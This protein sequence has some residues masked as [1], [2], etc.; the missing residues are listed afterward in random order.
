MPKVFFTADPHIHH[1]NIIH[2]CNR[3]FSSIEEMD[4]TI[5][6]NWNSKINNEDTVYI[7]GDFVLAWSFNRA[8]E[9]IKKLNGKKILILGNHDNPQIYKKLLIDKV[10]EGLYDTKKICIEG[11]IIWLSHYPHRS[12]NS[13]F[14]G[15]WHL[16]GHVHG[17][18]PDYGFSTDV[19]MDKWNFYPVSFEEL[20]EYFDDRII[21]LNDNV[22]DN[23]KLYKKNYETYFVEKY[24]ERIKGEADKLEGLL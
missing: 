19:G 6:K 10:I 14:H 20:R 4:E 22:R 17:R 16:F 5:I 7:L 13:S 21:D 8:S 3:P 2:Y 1:K 9:T 15:A 23:Y 11:K 12:W 18:I 24:I